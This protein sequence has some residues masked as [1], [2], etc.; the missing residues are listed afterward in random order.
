MDKHSIQHDLSP[1]KAKEVLEKA[2]E[3]YCK[4]FYRLSPQVGWESENEMNI[5][6][7]AM[8]SPVKAKLVINKNSIDV[9]MKLPVLFRAFRGQAIKVIDREVSKWIE[10][11]RK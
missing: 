5:S 1:E 3:Q 2:S 8:G 4:E 6:F 9:E 11:S 10:V 7:N